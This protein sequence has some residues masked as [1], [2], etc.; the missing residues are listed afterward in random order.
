MNYKTVLWL[1]EFLLV[2]FIGQLIILA[3]WMFT[4]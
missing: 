4:T 2:M 1:I 3:W